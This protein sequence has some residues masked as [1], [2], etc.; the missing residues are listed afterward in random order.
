MKFSND[1][2]TWFDTIS[3]TLNDVWQTP[4]DQIQM[5]TLTVDVNAR[6]I[7]IETISYY[8]Q[9]AGLQFV[10]FVYDEI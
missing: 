1:A 3:E 2:S 8:G 4:C 10:D 6:Y 5:Q 9:G 7:K